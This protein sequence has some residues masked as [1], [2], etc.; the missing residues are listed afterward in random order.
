MKKIA[1]ILMLA[2][3][4]L[5]ASV[6]AAA[7]AKPVQVD[8]F[9]EALSPEAW[10]NFFVVDAVQLRL[11][12]GLVS[13]N[14][15]VLVM[16]DKSGQWQSRKGEAELLEAG[17][18]AAVQS[19]YPDKMRLYLVARSLDTS[20]NGWRS[21]ARFAGIDPEVLDGQARAERDRLFEQNSKEAEG[22]AT[23]PVFLLNGAAYSDKIEPAVVLAKLNEFLPSASRVAI[24]AAKQA[25]LQM[26]VA[27][28]DGPFGGEPVRITKAL[29]RVFGN[30]DAT[31][32]KVVY[33]SSEYKKDFKNVKIPVLPTFLFKYDAETAETLKAVTG[34]EI[35]RA[36]DYLLFSETSE[37]AYYPD[38]KRLSK[39]LELFVMSQCPYGVMAENTLYDAIEA[40]AL[41]KNVKVKVHYIV[42]ADKKDG[43]WEFNSLHG[44]A[45]WMENARQMFIQARHPEKFWVYLKARNENYRAAEWE[46][47]AKKAGLNPEEI[48]K[49]FEE[50]KNLLAEDAKMAR[51]YRISAS[52]TFVWEG[53]SVAPGVG[54]LSR[55]KGFENV[56]TG[57][58][59][60]GS[61]N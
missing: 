19:H 24:P 48:K 31:A 37:G 61:C 44:E 6:F 54:A 42:E 3:A 56:K 33:G 18:M 59:P 47:A 60:S 7:A 50:G 40:K 27:V 29:G 12:A 5:P 34:T 43:Q 28:S 39:V 13:V 15:H 23:K 41:P 46:D 9:W 25:A 45:E 26:W 52:P 21:A 36:G 2:A 32:K 51:D 10:R 38:R 35:V 1:I 58:K 20:F 4:G 22:K 53:R 16:K 11:P 55:I 57:G 17:R 49:G 14:H 30:D 8:L